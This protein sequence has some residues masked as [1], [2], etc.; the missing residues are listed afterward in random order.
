MPHQSWLRG[1]GW[2]DPLSEGF[3]TL[4]DR[5]VEKFIQIGGNKVK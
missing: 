3:L 1:I 5:L 4:L 2:D